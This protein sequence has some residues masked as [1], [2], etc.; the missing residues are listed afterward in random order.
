MKPTEGPYYDCPESN[1]ITCETPQD[2]DHNRFG[3]FNKPDYDGR[4]LIAES[5]PHGPTRRLLA[6]SWDM[7]EA[8][9]MVNAMAEARMEPDSMDMWWA[10]HKEI[11]PLLR[12]IE[13]E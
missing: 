2:V 7:R 5:I 6:K 9:K 3:G 8:L 4:Y 13:G 1:A 11:A 10:L 12:S